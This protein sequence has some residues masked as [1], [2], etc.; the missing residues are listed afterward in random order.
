MTIVG[1]ILGRGDDSDD[2][3][4]ECARLEAELSDLA[5]DWIGRAKAAPKTPEGVAKRDAY[6]TAAEELTQAQYPEYE[7]TVGTIAVVDSDGE[8]HLVRAEAISSEDTNADGSVSFPLAG[9]VQHVCQYC[10]EEDGTETP[11]E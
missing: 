1:A 11:H 4:A 8:R 7:T 3:P 9:E 10:V 2:S 6:F 5:L